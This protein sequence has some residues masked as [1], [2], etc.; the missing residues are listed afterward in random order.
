M[1]ALETIGIKFVKSHG[2]NVYKL[3][4]TELDDIATKRKWV[5]SYD[6]YENDSDDDEDFILDEKDTKL[7]Y[8]QE[9]EKALQKIKN[10]EK[11]TK[12]APIEEE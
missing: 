10:M 8:K 11:L 1:E 4:L 2:Q 7:H 3:S 5:C 12:K 9:L 6:E